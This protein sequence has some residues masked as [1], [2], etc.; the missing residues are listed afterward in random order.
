MLRLQTFL[1]C[2]VP[3]PVGFAS[4]DSH[5]EDAAALEAKA[6]PT[7]RHRSTLRDEDAR[8][9]RVWRLFDSDEEINVSDSFGRGPPLAPLHFVADRF[10]TVRIPG[11]DL[12]AVVVD[13]PCPV[14]PS[15]ATIEAHNQAFGTSLTEPVTGD[16]ALQFLMNPARVQIHPS[17]LRRSREFSVLGTYTEAVR[18]MLLANDFVEALLPPLPEG[19]E[20]SVLSRGD[21]GAGEEVTLEVRVGSEILV[22]KRMGRKRETVTATL[23]ASVH[24]RWVRWTCTDAKPAES[25]DSPST[26]EQASRLEMGRFQYRSGIH[27]QWIAIGR[28]P[29]LRP[30][31]DTLQA[32]NL[33][34]TYVPEGPAPISRRTLTQAWSSSEHDEQVTTTH[35]LYCLE[36]PVFLQ[37]QHGK[38]LACRVRRTG[39]EISRNLPGGASSWRGH[40]FS[41]PQPGLVAIE[42]EGDPEAVQAWSALQPRAVLERQP[43]NSSPVGA[44]F[45]EH[46]ERVVQRIQVGE[47][48]R[49]AIPLEPESEMLLPFHCQ[50]GAKRLQFGAAACKDGVASVEETLEIRVEL[51]VPGAEP[52][53]LATFS[54]DSAQQQWADFQVDLPPEVSRG[55]LCWSVSGAAHGFD[56]RGRMSTFFVSIANPV[57][58][59][60]E[61]DGRGIVLY[62]VDTLRADHLQIYGYERD[63][64]PRLMAL[65]DELVIFESA[66]SVASWTRPATASLLT[67]VHPRFH[68]AYGHCAL[69]PGVAT[70]TERLHDQG[71]R[72]GALVLNPNVNLAGLGFDRGFEEFRVG[73]EG[74]YWMNVDA[75]DVQPWIDEWVG[76]RRHQPFFLYVHVVDPHAPYAPAEEE[77]RR[78]DPD[79]QGK[80]TGDPHGENS[81]S[82]PSLT[83]RDFEHVL[84]LYDG[85][86]RETDAAIGALVDSLRE[87]GLYDQTSL[88]ITADHGEEFLDHGSLFHGGRLYQEQVR[89]PLLWKPPSGCDVAPG[90]IRH[91]AQLVDVMPTVLSQAG[92]HGEPRDEVFTGMDLLPVVRGQ[93]SEEPLR[94]LLFEEPSYDLRGVLV[95]RWK[96]I[97]SP[98]ASA[99]AGLFYLGE[100]P[101][102]LEDLRGLR[103][104]QAEA[105][106]TVLRTFFAAHVESGALRPAVADPQVIDESQL[107]ELQA[108]GYLR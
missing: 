90:V 55:Q 41:N 39:E 4:C 10:R 74:T 70:L 25:D 67:G 26:F 57:L 14:D 38:P 11:Q 92:R 45:G 24:S 81:V 82:D 9:D 75:L 103:E 3:L 68:G 59:N 22:R 32:G 12:D 76:R 89:I 47:E 37:D 34:L 7:E 87:K 88:W 69:D 20:V 63:T 23:P 46:E 94:P 58:V 40:W 5:S 19:G 29:D 13:L 73:I 101:G 91:R 93:T 1:R 80:I 48:R 108:F 106:E 33:S 102:E 77:W 56:D 104:A 105:L 51:R 98:A 71:F 35:W 36:G 6:D 86:I 79:Y 97:D 54:V 84:A 16:R 44:L 62:V 18:V 52:S 43:K 2:L 50:N 64:T 31:I 96:L 61:A 15:Y 65:E 100:D 30:V 66:Y 17:Q 78:F 21:T 8:D 99:S 72:T 85:E 49:V 53:A 27:D 107:R 60:P 42:L 83:P 95:D 28:E